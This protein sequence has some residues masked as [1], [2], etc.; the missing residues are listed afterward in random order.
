MLAEAVVEN[1]RVDP[2]GNRPRAGGEGHTPDVLAPDVPVLVVR[3][4]AG[5][6]ARVDEV[7]FA[8]L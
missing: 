8:G 5:A 3:A 6:E 4:L 2:L 7:L 1:T